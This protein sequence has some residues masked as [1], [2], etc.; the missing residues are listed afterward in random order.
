[1]IAVL[2]KIFSISPGSPSLLLPCIDLPAPC[3]NTAVPCIATIYDIFD[4]TYLS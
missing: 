4:L 2:L 3:L 1:M